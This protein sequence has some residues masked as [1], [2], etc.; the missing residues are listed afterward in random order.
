MTLAAHP[1]PDPTTPDAAPD[2]VAD[3]IREKLRAAPQPLK[4]ADVVKGLTR[5]KKVKPADFQGLAREAIDAAFLLGQAFHYP[6]GPKGVERFWGRD[7]K[8]ALRDAAVKAA[9]EP[10]TLAAL[11]TAV[12]KAVKGT[13]PEFIDGVVRGLIGEDQLF[14]HPA[15]T[16]A[17]GP[18]FAATA[19]PPQL[20]PLLR[21][22][23]RK[24]FDTFA[25]SAGK[26]LAEAGASFDDLVAALR[27]VL[28]PSPEPTTP[29]AEPTAPIAELDALIL[30][31][32]AN[33]GPGW[34]VSL[35]DLRKDMPAKYRG[36][37]FDAAVLRLANERRVSVHRDGDP[38]R[39]TP[40]EQ[41]EY[42]SDGAGHLFTSI[43]KR[44]D[45]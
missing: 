45:Q 2:P 5:P 39:F 12:G 19:P 44:G 22:K 38:A 26:L 9:A 29:D 1:D 32:V 18:L 43:A 36:Q 23:F 31:A 10:K 11:R 35:A 40:E 24:K 20:P 15:K 33:A 25:K 8:Q 17:G 30:D 3:M 13:N 41:A 27:S 37:V 14:E 28:A 7:E 42:V 21:P 6:S 34:V 4:L 16:K